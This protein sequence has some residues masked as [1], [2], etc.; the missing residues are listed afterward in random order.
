MTWQTVTFEL[1]KLLIA[2]LVGAGGLWGA[3]KLHSDKPAAAAVTIT[4]DEL[5]KLYCP[6]P[7]KR[8]KVEGNAFGTLTK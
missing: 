8:A 1:G 6:A 5:R 2:A 4:A 3:Q 7:A